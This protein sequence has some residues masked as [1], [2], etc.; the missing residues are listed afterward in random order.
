MIKFVYIQP[1]SIIP[2]C[3]NVIEHFIAYTIIR[4]CKVYIDR[5]LLYTN[6]FVKIIKYYLHYDDY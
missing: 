5:R 1:T 4:T 3:Y 6:T 2:I